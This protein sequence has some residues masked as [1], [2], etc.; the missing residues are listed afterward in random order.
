MTIQEV[1]NERIVQ[2]NRAASKD[3]KSNDP[4][5]NRGLRTI[6]NFGYEHVMGNPDVEY[7]CKCNN[8]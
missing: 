3:H 5:Y 7:W 2:I 4:Q 8:L 1:K 6:K